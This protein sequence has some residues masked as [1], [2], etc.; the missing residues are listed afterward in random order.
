VRFLAYCQ[1]TSRKTILCYTSPTAEPL[2]THLLTLLAVRLFYL[3]FIPSENHACRPSCF[4]GIL[5][6]YSSLNTATKQAFQLN[7]LLLYYYYYYYYYCSTA[8]CWALAFFSFLILYTVGK[9][10]STG[11]QSVVRPLP[12]YRTTQTE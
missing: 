7:I 2:H 6:N 5:T 8:L 3:H 11:D 1:F 9:T 4:R 12:T 10:P